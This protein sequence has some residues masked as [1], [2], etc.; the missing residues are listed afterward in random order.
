MNAFNHDF[1][2]GR[3]KTR[4]LDGHRIAIMFRI[5]HSSVVSSH[6]RRSSVRVSAIDLTRRDAIIAAIGAPLL[7]RFDAMANEL[8]PEGGEVK[9]SDEVK[10]R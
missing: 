6:Q 1:A 10:K 4:V 9:M 8:I 5:K 7:L 3:G 2:L